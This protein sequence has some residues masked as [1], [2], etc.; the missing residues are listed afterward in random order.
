VASEREEQ[1]LRHQSVL[2]KFGELDLRSDDL[3]E[4]LPQ[5]CRLVAEALGTDLAKV[6]ELQEDG[7]TLLMHA[8]IGW[9]PGMVGEA[10]I[11]AD[12][13]FSESYALQIA[14]PVICPDVAAET[15]FRCAEFMIEAGVRA[16]V[17]VIVIGGE[18]KPPYGILQVDS[19]E[20]RAFAETEFLRTYA[21][22]L[23]AAV[24]RLR[25]TAGIRSSAT[26]QRGIVQ[27]ETAPGKGTTVPA[28]PARFMSRIW[29][30]RKTQCPAP[31]GQSCWSR[32]N[33]R[34][35]S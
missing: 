33:G 6:M 7:T 27:I 19:R 13:G 23:S 21:N 1:L 15:R 29:K 28:L 9:Q 22:L 4:I 14:K 30:P 35:A 16:F 26:A 11:G 12:E 25:V 2:A 18:G 31:A 10:T 34:Y 5:A 20:P 8:G 17:N 24:T 3:A 32:T